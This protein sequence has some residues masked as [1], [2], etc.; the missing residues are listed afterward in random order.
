M[1]NSYEERAM[2]QNAT[3]NEHVPGVVVGVGSEVP[4]RTDPARF[5]R[6]YRMNRPFAIYI[7]RIDAN[8]GCAELFDYFQRYAM[9]FP[10]G[11][12]LVLVGKPIIPIPAHH[13]IHHLGYLSDEDKFDALS[14]AD[15]LIMPSYF[16]SLS[17]VALEAWALGRPVLANGRCDVLKGQCIRSNAGLYYESY[18]EF[19]ETLLLARIE[20]PAPR[21]AREERPRVLPS[22]L[23]LAGHRAEVPGHV[24]AARARRRS[25]GARPD[26]RLVRAAPARASARDGGPL[27]A[28]IGR[29]H[30]GPGRTAGQ[31]RMT[32]RPRVHQVLATLGY[33][34][35]IGHEV[36]GVQRV[37]R[38][39]GYESEIFVETA[40]HRLEDC[41]ID[42]REM[43]GAIAPEDV[44]VHHFSI[45][46]RA[47]RTAYALPG[48]MALVYHNITPPQYFVGIHRDLVKQCFRGRRELTAYIERSDLALGDS[49]YNRQELESL[50]FPRTGVL[51]VVP[52]FNHLSGSPNPLLAAD[53]D[54]GW[55]NVMFVGRVIPNKKFETII[56]A[57]HVYRT[58]HNPRARLLLVG[59]YSGFERY[60]SMLQEL[61]ASLGTPDVHFLGHVSNEELTALYDVADVFLC[62]S[63]HEGFCVPI[64]EAFYKGVPV[65]AY[66]STA[67]PATM[68]GGGVLYD[69]TDPFE[70]ARLMEAVLDDP[71]LEEAI[72][73]SQDAALARLQ[74][75]D[76]PGT[77]LR[78]VEELI[79]G[80]P[81][82]CAGRRVGFLGPVRAVR[83]V[84]RIAPVQTGTVSGFGSPRDQGSGIRLRGT[85]RRR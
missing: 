75:R 3:E 37:L 31:K 26:T 17:M 54:D 69:T 83:T 45:G 71:A 9:T 32:A 44:L 68:D 10:R 55:T 57:F 64:I 73:R 13:R 35:A 6:R 14:A 4:A 30:A 85:H 76:F 42:Y 82:A 70:I 12:D 50:G 61:I 74:A 67:V 56:R 25:S 62:A 15:L 79:A 8:K 39:A 1:Y 33:G 53:F 11:L 60:L 23:L 46:S 18:E 51:P 84:R 7:G 16:E 27:A 80:P 47:S 20:R 34:D 65:L 43:V 24:Q 52:D 19:A 2:I 29:R 40:D 78:F 5:R 77:L 72:L 58:R 49:E 28:A 38:S 66:A 41:T 59:S 22:P 48:R 81:Q 21:Q 63:A 36:L